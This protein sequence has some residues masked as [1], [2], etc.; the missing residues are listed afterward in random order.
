MTAGGGQIDAGQKWLIPCVEIHDA[1]RY[2]YSG[3]HL[4]VCRHYFP[5]SLIKKYLDYMVMHKF[6]KF[7]W[8]LT[9]DQGWRR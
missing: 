8:H 6:N 2:E 3:L 1:P 7:H 5:V 9:E 4:D